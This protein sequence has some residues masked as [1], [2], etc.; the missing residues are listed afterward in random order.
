MITGGE[1]KRAKYSV[2]GNMIELSHGGWCIW[3]VCDQYPRVKRRDQLLHLQDDVTERW[4]VDGIVCRGN[5]VED[6]LTQVIRMLMKP[7]PRPATEENARPPTTMAAQVRW[8][9]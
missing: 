1:L 5:T 3:Y 9:S 6:Q 4:Y 7:E 8:S 2:S